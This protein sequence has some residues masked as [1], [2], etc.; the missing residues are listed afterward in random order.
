MPVTPQVQ[1]I[2]LTIVLDRQDD[3]SFATNLSADMQVGFTGT[4]T[5]F[6]K[7]RRGGSFTPPAFIGSQTLSGFRTALVAAAK[8]ECND[9]S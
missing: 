3:G 2:R 8:A 9:P 1:Q 5:G 4:G 6:E 7:K